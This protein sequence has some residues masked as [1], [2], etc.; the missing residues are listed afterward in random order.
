MQRRKINAPQNDLSIFFC[1]F[2]C[3][4]LFKPFWKGKGNF[5]LKKDILFL[6]TYPYGTSVEFNAHTQ[7][8]VP[9]H[10]VDPDKT[11]SDWREDVTDDNRMPIKISPKHLKYDELDK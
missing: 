6:H 2:V 5:S 11:C 10:R 1:L 4:L 7:M 3:F 8:A 9:C